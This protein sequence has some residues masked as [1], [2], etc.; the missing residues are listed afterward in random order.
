MAER[1]TCELCLSACG[2]ISRPQSREPIAVWI[3]WSLNFLTCATRS[4]LS[5]NL[6]AFRSPCLSIYL[7]FNLHRPIDFLFTVQTATSKV[8]KLVQI[9]SR[10]NRLKSGKLSRLLLQSDANGQDQYWRQLYSVILILAILDS[11]V[12]RSFK[13]FR[14]RKFLLGRR[15]NSLSST[16]SNIYWVW[17][18]TIIIE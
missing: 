9:R 18:N 2:S 1:V 13:A 16:L 14:G 17:L 10:S 12:S 15:S 3:R 11:E 6:F 4:Y 5:F 7:P 8:S